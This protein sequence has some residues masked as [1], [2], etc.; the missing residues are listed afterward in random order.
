[1]GLWG[2]ALPLL[3]HINKAD[4]L[5]SMSDTA[6][7]QGDV[8]KEEQML[9]ASL[10]CTGHLMILTFLNLHNSLQDRYPVPCL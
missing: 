2:P 6:E 8:A 3:H 1:M 9:T 5:F 10:L 7:N 4:C